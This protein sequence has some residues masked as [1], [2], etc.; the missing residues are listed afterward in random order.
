MN[1]HKQNILLTSFILLI[2]STLL[3]YC[4]G[5]KEVAKEDE[6]KKEE[7][8]LSKLDLL[9]QQLKKGIISLDVRYEIGLEYFKLGYLDSAQTEF[10]TVVASN[11]KKA[12]VKYKLGE[13][14]MAQ[15]KI[16]D[17]LEIFIEVLQDDSL[18]NNFIEQVS[19]F[20]SDA[21]QVTR[22]TNNTAED[23]FPSFNFKTNQIVFQSNRDGNW[24]IYLMELDGS[25]QTRLTKTPADEETPAFSWDGK[26]IAY[27]YNG[28]D[29]RPNV[30]QALKWREIY[31]IDATGFSRTRLTTN[32]SDDWSPNFSPDGNTI[33]FCSERNDV[34][35]VP[36]YM[37]IS[38]IY[39]MDTNGNFQKGLFES[40]EDDVSPSFSSDGKKIIFS[41]RRNKKFRIS[42]GNSDGTG[43]TQSLGDNIGDNNSPKF[44]PDGS[45]IVFFSNRYGDYSIFVMNADGSNTKA[46]TSIFKNEYYPAFSGDGTKVAFHSDREGNYE[47]Y[48]MDLT[49]PVILT[50]EEI[51]SRLKQTI[52]S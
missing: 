52:G 12:D 18:G 28:D 50:K 21:F 5:G 13:I 24:E 4:A 33:T 11:P 35:P 2:I 48:V 40:P 32:T 15:G 47:V 51:I 38:N 45:R 41:S 36:F 34:R 22:L 44:S 37:V 7:L 8:K 17:A 10:E 46:L 39:I 27:S 16:K 26:L 31:V 25:N 6:A 30:S 1:N 42:I 14:Y 3:I 19:S 29:I 9:K 43:D 20:V 49:K 23:G